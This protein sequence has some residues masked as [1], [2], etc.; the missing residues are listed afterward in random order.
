MRATRECRSADAYSEL[1]ENVLRGEGLERVVARSS[2]GSS[3]PAVADQLVGAAVRSPFVD[4]DRVPMG[5]A[6]RVRRNPLGP[7]P[8]CR[9]RCGALISQPSIAPAG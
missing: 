3:D 7:P 1:A 4:L 5:L 2:P 6:A 8:A 9:G